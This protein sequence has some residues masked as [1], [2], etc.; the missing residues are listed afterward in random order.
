[1]KFTEE[2]CKILAK[3]IWSGKCP[4]KIIEDILG[5]KLPDGTW[6]TKDLINSTMLCLIPMKDDELQ[7]LYNRV[8]YHTRYKAQRHAY[9]ENKT[10][11]KSEISFPDCWDNYTDYLE[12]QL[13]IWF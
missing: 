10:K 4:T 13:G 11:I 9:Y 8:T 3:E 2:K 1:M 12:Y 7:T 5:H 6:R